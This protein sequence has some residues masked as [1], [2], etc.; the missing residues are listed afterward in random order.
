MKEIVSN[1]NEDNLTEWYIEWGTHMSREEIDEE[2]KEALEELVKRI[3]VEEEALRETK[4]WEEKVRKMTAE[5]EEGGRHSEGH[6]E[7][8]KC[9]GQ[10]QG[11]YHSES[12]G[13][14]EPSS[15]SQGESSWSD[16]LPIP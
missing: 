14:G 9:H 5:A 2:V 12:H 8:S 10:A 15:S 4:G 11:K 3:E 7:T 16:Y 1:I 6:V 13:Q